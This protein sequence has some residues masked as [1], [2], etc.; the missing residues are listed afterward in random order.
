MWRHD[1]APVVPFVKN[2]SVALRPSELWI[3]KACWAFRR[4]RCTVRFMDGGF[5][6]GQ[7]PMAHSWLFTEKEAVAVRVGQAG[8]RSLYGV[9]L[10]PPRRFCV[11]L[12][13]PDNAQA[14]NHLQLM[15]VNDHYE[16]RGDTPLRFTVDGV[17]FS[18]TVYELEQGLKNGTQGLQAGV[19]ELVRLLGTPT[20]EAPPSAALTQATPDQPA[21]EGGQD[22]TDGMEVIEGDGPVAQAAM[23]LAL[24]R[25]PKKGVG[26]PS[27]PKA[28]GR[29]VSRKVD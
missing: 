14:V 28:D 11:A 16:L 15:E 2:Q 21:D 18:Y 27:G 29:S 25:D 23:R 8:G 6:D 24:R 13:D 10:R 7:A 17:K 3:C 1:D 20:P 4:R 22:E 19:R 9:L 26:R 12:L 5:K